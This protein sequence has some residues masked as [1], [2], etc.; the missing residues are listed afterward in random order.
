MDWACVQGSGGLW[1]MCHPQH[2]LSSLSARGFRRRGG[3]GVGWRTAVLPSSSSP[4][5]RAGAP[6][7]WEPLPLRRPYGFS[8]LS[9]TQRWCL[10]CHP[11]PDLCSSLAPGSWFLLEAWGWGPNRLMGSQGHWATSCP[12]LGW[13]PALTS[14]L[15]FP[16][17]SSPTGPR[18]G[19][20][21]GG[22][23]VWVGLVA[24]G[25]NPGAFML[26]CC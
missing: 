2:L 7:S 14:G 10:P 6:P 26:N 22:S 18:L 25:S 12:S 20:L 1:L 8:L 4:G 21:A 17:S 15:E 23:T 11:D 9:R 19:L 5:C 13:S 3:Q 24:P 16:S